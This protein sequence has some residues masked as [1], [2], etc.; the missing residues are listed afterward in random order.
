M[1]NFCA[2]QPK[3]SSN[4]LYLQSAYRESTQ[5]ND[6]DILRGHAKDFRV[7]KQKIDE[8]S[9]KIHD[10]LLNLADTDSQDQYLDLEQSN[11]RKVIELGMLIDKCDINENEQ[12][13]DHVVLD[14][15]KSLFN[16]RNKLDDN[17]SEL[18]ELKKQWRKFLIDNDMSQQLQ[19][20]LLQMF[21]KI[22]LESGNNKQILDGIKDLIIDHKELLKVLLE[23]EQVKEDYTHISEILIRRDQ[24]MKSYENIYNDLQERFVMSLEKIQELVS[25]FT[26]INGDQKLFDQ[27]RQNEDA[28]QGLVQ[29]IDLRLISAFEDQV[30]IYKDIKIDLELVS[31]KILDLYVVLQEI[32][33]RLNDFE[34]TLQK[35][36]EES[37]RQLDIKILLPYIQCLSE[38]SFVINEQRD[39]NEE[40]ELDIEHKK[41]IFGESNLDEK[42][43]SHSQQSLQQRESINEVKSE[44]RTML[45]LLEDLKEY[46]SDEEESQQIL[47]NKNS[48]LSMKELIKSVDEQCTKSELEIENLINEVQDFSARGEDSEKLLLIEKLMSIEKLITLND[49]AVNKI[50][51]KLKKKAKTFSFYDLQSKYKKRSRQ[52]QQSSFLR[53]KVK[54]QIQKLRNNNENMM[55]QGELK[56]DQKINEFC[57]LQEKF[58]KVLTQ[59]E[60]ILQEKIF[61][62]IPKDP[63][64]IKNSEQNKLFQRQQDI[65]VKLQDL[66]QKYLQL[67]ESIQ[68]FKL[69]KQ[70]SLNHNK[71]QKE[72]FRL[73]LYVAIPG[74]EIDQQV[75]EYINK[76]Q[77]Q[78]PI[79]VKIQRIDNALYQFGSKKIS[80]KVIKNSLMV[81]LGGGYIS[82]EDF[83]QT[84][85]ERELKKQQLKETDEL[86]SLSNISGPLDKRIKSFITLNGSS[87][88]SQF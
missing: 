15:T 24:K 18:F 82:L 88:S 79:P 67:S 14:F 4:N 55:E 69:S 59:Q 47:T 25:V 57:D 21:Q 36:S 31:D 84:Y 39:L 68:N 48:I 26:Q 76:A 34:R 74:D 73:P 49:N 11:E 13:G 1:G 75:A 58:S 17:E 52:I 45:G 60:S 5:A 30:K 51:E 54:R 7:N 27:V 64:S 77:E 6:A 70:K 3:K 83:I 53:D 2:C 12:L 9:Q 37:L 72:T 66:N 20:D 33:N 10:F 44:V 85:G 81:K 46:A 8:L 62:H 65:K 32:L 43:Q 41:L 87:K 50:N 40:V 29:A 80:I 63:L 56:I 86:E 61:P 78:E 71:N 38:L 35:H 42:L 28:V 23:D 19:D 22:Q 16:Y